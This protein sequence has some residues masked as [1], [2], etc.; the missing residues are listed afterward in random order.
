ME[1]IMAMDSGLIKILQAFKIYKLM[2]EILI[3]KFK[4]FIQS[5]DLGWKT[6]S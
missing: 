1:Q 2:L 4:I 6:L 3:I 5:V